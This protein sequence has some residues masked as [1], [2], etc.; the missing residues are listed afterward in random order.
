[1]QRA[2]EAQ[3][4]AVHIEA[5]V[6]VQQALYRFLLADGIY[7]LPVVSVLFTLAFWFT[8]SVVKVVDNVER[9]VGSLKH[10]LVIIGIA[11]FAVWMLYEFWKRWVVTGDPKEVPLI[12]EKIVKES[13]ESDSDGA[14]AEPGQSAEASEMERKQ[15][16]Q[17]QPGG[18]R[19]K[20]QLKT[21]LLAGGI[22]AVVCWVAYQS[23]KR[24][25]K[26]N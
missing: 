2:P 13:H 10:Y 6:A 22:V 19:G 18:P 24:W 4:F 12:G 16:Q 23:V 7:A 1:M 15:V 3:P 20:S 5:A 9:H 21:Y 26:K 25:P 17:Q 8:D 14:G 11:T